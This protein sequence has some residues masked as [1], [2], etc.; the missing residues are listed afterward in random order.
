[1]SFP[2]HHSTNTVRA[3]IRRHTNMPSADVSAGRWSKHLAAPS[4]T[5]SRR[6]TDCSRGKA[7]PPSA[8]NR[9]IY[10]QA[11]LMD[12]GFTCH[13]PVRPAPYASY[14]VL[15]HRLVPLLHASSRPRLA[16]TPLR[17]A[18]LHHHQVVKGTCT[19][20]L[21]NYP[22]HTKKAPG[23]APGSF[24]PFAKNST[25]RLTAILACEIRWTNNQATEAWSRPV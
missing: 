12:M 1:M 24:V 19:P 14:L 21:S 3:F 10:N 2:A 9:R 20:K 4:V 22:P 18:S 25:Y 5:N 17:F 16:T 15:V 6:A 23:S 13:W 11:L 8:R 7:R